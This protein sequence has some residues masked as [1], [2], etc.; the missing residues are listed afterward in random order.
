[1]ARSRGDRRTAPTG[2]KPPSETVDTVAKQNLEPEP[3]ALAGVRSRVL[4]NVLTAEVMSTELTSRERVALRLGEVAMRLIGVID[5]SQGATLDGI[6]QDMA[7]EGRR[8]IPDAECVIARIDADRPERFRIVGG[9]GPWAKPLVGKEYP[10]DGTLNGRAMVDRAVVETVNA[11]EDSS[12]PEVFA[13]GGIK[14]GRLIPLLGTQ[15]LPGARIALGAIGFWVREARAFTPH[16]RQL[17]DAYASIVNMGMGRGQLREASQRTAERLRAGVEAALELGASLDP[18]VV[19][20]RLL[21]STV[22]WLHADRA[23]LVHVH[24]DL[25]EVEGCHD[26]SPRAHPPYPR[27]TR[28]P[29]GDQFK[30]IVDGGRPA[31]TPYDPR[32]LPPRARRQM[33][34]VKSA[35]TVPLAVNGNYDAAITAMRRHD[36]P[37]SAADTELLQQVGSIAAQATRNASLYSEAKTAHEQAVQTLSTISNHVE[38]SA[39]LPQFMRLLSA[40]IADLVQAEKVGLWTYDMQTDTLRIEGQQEGSSDHV[41]PDLAVLPVGR[42]SRSLTDRVVF[43]DHRARLDLKRDATEGDPS[44][45]AF[46]AAGIRDVVMVPWKAGDVSLGLLGAYNS[47]RPGGFSE[48]DS[49]VLQVAALATG[50]VWRQ[51]LSER[52]AAEMAEADAAAQRKVAER[53]QELERVKTEFLLLASHELRG[54]VAVIHGYTSMLQEGVIVGP[55]AD[56][57]LGMMRAKAEQMNGLIRAMLDTARLEDGRL[58]LH[59]GRHDLVEIVESALS[60]TAPMLTSAHRLSRR[61]PRVPVPVTVDR[62]RMMT[63]VTNLIGNAIK[64]SPG[65]GEIRCSL[66]VRDGSARVRIGDQGLGI[67]PEDMPRLFTR[68]GRLVT[69]DNSHIPGT[70][71]G[72]YLAREFANRSGGT[73]TVR[74]KPGRGSIFTLS[75]PTASP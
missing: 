33:R 74:S 12:M 68:F 62:E 60:S 6:A 55:A 24:R 28:L 16:E 15:D 17:M 53:L 20:D 57:A 35:L 37:F 64:Y 58:E 1:M 21:R 4:T 51:K 19:V 25:I 5:A 71:L 56:H 72:L 10:L 43:E 47:L 32:P 9:A 41:A 46:D 61:L 44:N 3:E 31:I 22:R 52:H 26:V 65:G 13:A 11:G 2:L 39:D 7:A 45:A 40:T 73:I 23:T 48:E 63:A 50:F 75:L 14:A 8:L 69:S 67:G 59:V 27:G 30:R 38:S 66:T 36:L 54:P 42:G 18:A 70:G 29:M 49:W 34:G